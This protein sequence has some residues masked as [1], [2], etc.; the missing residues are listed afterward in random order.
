MNYEPHLVA[1]LD[2]LGFSE[3][4]LKSESSESAR[5]RLSNIFTQCDE[6]N[7][8]A[9]L[10]PGKENINTIIVSDSIVLTLKLNEAKPSISE[11]RNFILGAGR[12]QYNLGKIGIWLRGG[13]SCGALYVDLIQK[14]VVGPA[15]IHA[16]GLEKNVAKVPRIIADSSIMNQAGYLSAVEFRKAVNQNGNTDRLRPFYEWSYMMDSIGEAH[17]L[18]DVPFIVDFIRSIPPESPM[19]I[20]GH[21]AEGLRGPISHYEKYRWLA[22]YILSTYSQAYL[23]IGPDQQNLKTLLG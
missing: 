19:I 1:F 2:I 14:Q 21:V 13:I 20:A 11:I 8:S 15:L 4:C 9:S 6:I 3:V 17:I 23:S 16:V 7:H 12:F 5:D 18:N 22:D 10:I